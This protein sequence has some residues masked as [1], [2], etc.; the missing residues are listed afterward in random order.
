MT[1]YATTPE[2]DLTIL[3]GKAAK[4]DA[5]ILRF[6]E[7]TK[8]RWSPWQVYHKFG[9]RWPITSVRRSINTLTA[10]GKLN[11][12]GDTRKGRYGRKEHFW[13]IAIA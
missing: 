7:V 1:Y 6:F 5:A 8:R 3:R 11:K 10:E 9:D 13:I 12:L 4:Q 2:P